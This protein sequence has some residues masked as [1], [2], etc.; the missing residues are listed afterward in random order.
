M[1]II[2]DALRKIQNQESVETPDKAAAES[3]EP[4]EPSAPGEAPGQTST[5]SIDEMA[6]GRGVEPSFATTRMPASQPTDAASDTTDERHRFGNIPKMLLG[7]ILALGIFTTGWFV[8]RLYVD[9]NSDTSQEIPSVQASAAQPQQ[10]ARG[11][12]IPPPQSQPAAAQP[13]LPAPTVPVT[14]ANATPSVPAVPASPVL[15]PRTVSVPSAE[16]PPQP[17]PPVVKETRPRSSAAERR[18]AR[19]EESRPPEKEAKTER[20]GR[21]YLKINAIAWRAEE[22]KAIV[23]MQRVYVGDVIEGAKV[24]S[25]QKN[26]VTFEYKGETFEVRF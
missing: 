12:E 19:T 20:E 11:A 6:A 22:P 25:I 17:I 9:S 23:N 5:V 8:S 3:A 1:S 21:P 13:A 24:K 18:S 14:A 4:R 15:T 26:S 16:S 2:L 7:L 10:V